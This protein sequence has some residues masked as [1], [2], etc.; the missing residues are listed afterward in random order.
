MSV[1]K[2]YLVGGGPGDPGLLTLRGAECL[3]QADLVLYDGLVNPLLLRHSHASAL[4]TCRVDGP[5]GRRL[6]QQEINRQLVDAA[7]AGQTVV[8]LKGGDPFV[9]G[10]G[11]EEAAALAE[12]GIPFEIVPG[13]TAATACAAYAG[14]SLTHRDHA[15]AVAFV[16]GHE[17]PAKDQSALHYGEL[18]R[19]PGTLVFYMGLHRLGDIARALI[20]NGKAATTP[21]AVICRGTTPQQRTVS[22]TLEN[23]AESA[24]EA[25]LR[26]PSLIVVGDCVRVR[27]QIPWFE[28]RP[29]LG[30]N[31]GITTPERQA[32][33]PIRH[34]LQLG[35]QPILMPMLSTSP[36]DN[37]T[38]VDQ[39]I[40]E[41]PETD[42][43][44]F[45]SVNGVEAFLER[46]WSQGGD[47]RRLASARLAAIGE[48]TAARLQEYRLQPD[49]VPEVFRA[50][51]LAEALRPHVQ[52]RRVVWIRADRG[53]DILPEAMRQAGAD[54][55]EAVAYR[56]VDTSQLPTSAADLLR[57]GQ[58]HWIGL[59]S[60]AIARNLAALVR[61]DQRSTIRFAAISPV[62]AEAATG[63]GLNVSTVATTHTW[64][65]LLDAIK[66]AHASVNK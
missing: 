35:A 21:V 4:R 58:L 30:V 1:G 45:T 20:D 15:S 18:T 25:N 33:G 24:A 65:G 49:L 16:T 42:W 34:A 59:S 10:R 48:A 19:F 66:T 40:A 32:D 23:I 39:V 9:F 38:A 36:V 12:A 55:R 28:S 63:A 46:L 27:D 14:I 51:A 54:F 5:G 2:V 60:P 50:E 56:H 22:G 64:P 53:R 61:E 3:A 31:I 52:G 13:I 62:T 44:V 29:L 8:R 41:L 26:P 7:L 6:D 11:S 47:A 57:A 37:W 17:D 43:L